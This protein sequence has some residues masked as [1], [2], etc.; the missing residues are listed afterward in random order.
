LWLIY[1]PMSG[2]LSKLSALLRGERT[3]HRVET[4][5]IGGYC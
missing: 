1:S 4:R 2:H 5:F 3:T